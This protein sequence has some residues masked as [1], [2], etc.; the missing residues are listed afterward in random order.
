MSRKLFSFLPGLAKSLGPAAFLMAGASG[1]AAAYPS[2]AAPSYGVIQP[3]AYRTYAEEETAEAPAQLASCSECLT[4][5]DGSCEACCTMPCY[6]WYVSVSGA[7][8]TRETVHEVGDPATFI[9]FN[10]GFAINTA[11]GH[12]FELFRLEFEYSY[13]NNQVAT[14]GAGIPGVGNFVSDASGNISVKAYMLNVYHDFD[15]GGPLKPY[16]GAGIGLFQSEINSLLP[17]FFATLGTPTLGVNTTSDVCF[18]YQFRAGVNYELTRRTELF[19]GYRFFDNGDPL[20][21]A[22]EPFGVFYP[23]SATFH[24]LEAGLRVKF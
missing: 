21:F 8:S 6:C 20:T 23:D 24:N 15:F 7:W 14:A 19:T 11:L 2:T 1:A 22:A 18:A 16:V 9:E 12:E 4:C 13:F 17:S 5:D 10:D 3:V